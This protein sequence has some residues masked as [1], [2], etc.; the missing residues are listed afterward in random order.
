V[1]RS[2]FGTLSVVM[3]LLVLVLA[4]LLLTSAAQHA[5]IS[6][7]FYS[8]LLIVNVLGIVVLAGLITV[9]VWHLYRQ[10]RAQALGSR[11][12][13]RLLGL[14]VLL[15][16]IP[17]AVVYYFSVQFLSKG[18]DSWFDVRV[19]QAI[20][21][22]LLLG[23]T[24]LEVLK[25]DVVDDVS[26]G[27][28]GVTESSTSLEIIRLLDDL[29]ERGG[30]S[31]VSLFTL[32]GRIVAFSSQDAQSL[33]PDTPD[34]SVLNRVQK[35]EAYASLEPI[36]ENAQQLRIVVP[37][38]PTEVGKPIRALQALKPLPLRYANLSER[39]E[40]ASTQYKQMVFSRGPLK[41][42]LIL[43]LTLITLTA[44]LLSVWAA[45][46]I[47]RLV[48]APLRDLAEGTRAVARGNYRK[49]LPVTSS[50]EFGV[51][52]KSFNE[53]T[54]RINEAQN[55]AHRSQREAE[56]QRTYLET[57]LAH[58]SSGVLSFDA[59]LNLL[60][61]NT[62]A[63]QILGIT[64][65]EG[66][67]YSVG[68]IKKEHPRFESLFAVIE[69]SMN[70]GL[71]EW[72][73]P[74]TLFGTR[75][76]Q[77]LIVRGT[78][79]PGKRGGHVVVFDDVTDLI[80][81]QRDAAWGEV[82]RRLAHEIKNPLTPIQLSVE[83]IRQKYSTK[84]PAEDYETLDRATRTIAQQ[85]ESMKNMV[86]AFSNYA[87]PVQMKLKPVR[88]NQL[89][90]DV[91]ELHRRADSPIKL[92]FDLDEDLPELMA[93]T[94]R[95][96]QVLNNLLI[97]AKDAL[98]HTLHPEIRISTL[99]IRERDGAHIRL[100]VVDNGPGV[101]KD[102]MDGGALW[103]ENRE[104]GGARVTIQLPQVMRRDNVT[105]PNLRVNRGNRVEEKIA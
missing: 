21:D 103:A 54:Q 48:S 45:I 11:L 28:A 81:A 41:F 82:A 53:M 78:K 93:D 56:E 23:R 16:G 104:E 40:S 20:G 69:D 97:N 98:V 24:T 27:A 100:T 1:I 14:F 8:T 9:N 10:F 39:I 18:V 35:R 36:S 67:D 30:Y 3:L 83:R 31:E 96:R 34:E 2:L 49:E 47:S 46:Y 73:Q 70:K 50:D 55:T 64:F 32:T 88:L 22:A 6:G 105:D 94:D 13:M 89:V 90:Q 85:V 71:D 60:T 12:T 61:Q 99:S 19:E 87:Q 4:L 42:S 29:R 57:V 44:L 15:A 59:D 26:E 63:S 5:D 62:T 95:L 91:A 17:L 74:V 84:L 51:L 75:G 33:V 43:T 7:E 79:L 77:I 80:Q 72:Q 76:R 86:N 65:T 37:V 101:P 38:L 66:E 102:I 52:V 68:T 58:L 25:Q 92:V